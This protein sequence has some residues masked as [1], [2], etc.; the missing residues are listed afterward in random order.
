[1]P[2]VREARAEEEEDAVIRVYR[3][4]LKPP[5]LNADMVRE[6]IRGAHDYANDLVAI[7]RGRRGAIRALHAGPAVDAATEALR[8]ATRSTRKQARRALNQ[9]RRDAENAARCE[10]GHWAVPE[11]EADRYPFSPLFELERI[12]LLEASIRR[13]AYALARCAWGTRQIVAASADQARKTDLYDRKGLEPNDVKFR[14]AHFVPEPP[15]VLPGARQGEGQIAIHVQNRTLTVT[16]LLGG[17]DNQARLVMG[18]HGPDDPKA[19]EYGTL[20]LCLGT[21]DRRVPIWATFPIRTHRQLPDAGHVSY[22]R[23]SCRHDGPWIR[24]SCEITVD[25]R[26]AAPRSLDTSLDGAIALEPCWER[27]GDDLRVARWAD[28]RGASGE[29]LLPARDVEASGKLAGLRSVRDQLRNDLATRLQ[30]E[31]REWKEAPIWLAREATTMHLWK[32]PTRFHDVDTRC[33]REQLEGAAVRLLREWAARDRHLWQYEAGARGKLLGRRKDLYQCLT[34]SWAGQYRTL[35]VDTRNFSLLAR[36]GPESEL[37]FMAAPSELRDSA[38][39]AFGPTDV[40]E[41]RYSEEHEEDEHE[42]EI[43]PPDG[44]VVRLRSW[45]ELAIERWRDEQM[46]G[47]ARTEKKRKRIEH[48][49]GGAWAARKKQKEQRA[50][51]GMGARKSSSV[52]AE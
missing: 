28:S 52:A 40:V 30:R 6:H 25:D 18:G 8:V 35:I 45:P 15:D 2:A 46:A 33:R 19:R 38:R 7:E 14:R 49:E 27:P 9:A 20:W 47:G 16:Q 11:D 42:D 32:S 50:L 44:E 34:K 13:D 39:G 1:V 22:V 23:V 12:K 3:Y 10:G 29:I 31:I 37:R 41:Y 51:A 5:T 26:A 24:W 36:F 17:Q 48:K 21:V 4:Y 43:A